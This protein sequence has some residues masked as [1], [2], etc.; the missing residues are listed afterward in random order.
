MLMQ[1]VAILGLGIMGGGM[2]AN[3]LAKGFEVSVWNRTRAKADALAGKGAKVAATPREAAT[4]ADFI[5]AMVSDDDVSR[6]IWLGADGAL[7]GAKSGAIGVESSTLTPDWIRELGG[8]AQAKGVGFLD[9]PVGGSRPAADAG[10][11]RFFVGGDPKT[12]EAT[13]PALAAVGSRMDLLG[14]LGAGATWKLINNQLGAGQIAALA[15]ALEVARK[16]GFKAEKI[17]EL[18]LGGPAASPMVKLKLPRMLAHDFEPADFALNLM[19]KDARYAAALAQSLGAPAGVI[20]GAVKAF[21]R[22]DAKGLGAKD[23]AAVVG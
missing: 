2:A 21:A 1:R 6:A 19:L 17:S 5:F 15:E 22:A 4:G 10:E 3:W 20:E 13:R 8:K 12:Y 9:A 18:I 14:P 11:L 16:A 23:I 7:A